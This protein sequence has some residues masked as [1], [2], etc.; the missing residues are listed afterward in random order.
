MTQ[1]SGAGYPTF[2]LEV[3]QRPSIVCA[4]VALQQLRSSTLSAWTYSVEACS[5]WWNDRCNDQPARY[6]PH[7]NPV[8]RIWGALKAWLANNPTMTIQGHVGQAHAFFRE[9]SPAQMLATAA[10]HSS[11]WPPADYVQNFGRAA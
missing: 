9:R 2:R 3:G 10:P 7:D 8:K 6:S 1:R 5:S 4:A 11:P